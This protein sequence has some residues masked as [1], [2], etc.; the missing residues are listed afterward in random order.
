MEVDPT[1]SF[2][3]G[4]A[5]SGV[6]ELAVT[7]AIWRLAEPGDLALDVGAN[8]G[9]FSG[10]LST[11][12]RA[13]WAFE[14]HP[15]VG[16]RLARNAAHWPQVTVHRVAVSDREGTATLAEP[17]WFA[18][19]SGTATITGGDD[20]AKVFTVTIDATIGT[21]HVGVMKIDIE[22]HEY[23]AL[24]GAERAL[25]EQRIRDIL[26]EEHDPLPTPVTVL[27]EGFGYR[28]YG[29]DERF[30]TVDLARP[31][32]A[33]ASWAAPTFLATTDAARAERLMAPSGWQSLRRR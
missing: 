3:S 19:N 8:A 2:G 12:C 27:L 13:V 6:H 17:D 15:T 16:E 24:R 10:L 9:Y 21:E 29:L 30:R 18:R 28:I 1:E 14:P 4:V 5:R 26:F 33:H 22:G 25:S 23:P 20:G 31:E 32:R 7:E 11:R